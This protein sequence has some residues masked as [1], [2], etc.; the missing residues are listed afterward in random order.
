MERREEIGGNY[1]RLRA[2]TCVRLCCRHIKPSQR[3]VVHGE[4]I[5]KVLFSQYGFVF[6]RV[7]RW[8]HGW[9]GGR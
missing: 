4:G 8:N 1:L 3:G 5:Q 6:G 7:A 2:G 9:K